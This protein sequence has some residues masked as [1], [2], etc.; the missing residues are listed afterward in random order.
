[1]DNNFA[2]WDV[3][4]SCH[5]IGAKDSSIKDVVPSDLD[6]IFNHAAIEK[7]FANGGTAYRLYMKHCYPVF[8]YPIIQLPS[9]SPAN[10]SWSLERLTAAWEVIVR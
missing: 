6:V 10:A 2:L 3:I 9:T 8:G 5:I 1:L 7:V 4:A